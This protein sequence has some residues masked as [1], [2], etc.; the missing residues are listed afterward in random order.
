MGT[1]IFGC[2]AAES[3]DSSGEILKMDGLDISTLTHDGIFNYEH[4]NDQPNQVVG[5]ILFAKKLMSEED[6]TRPQEKY[7]WD[8]VKIPMLYV[9]GELFDDVGHSSAQ[10]IAAMLKYDD[11]MRKAGLLKDGKIK[12]MINFSIEGAKLENEGNIIKKSIA[13]KVTITIL[14]CNKVCEAEIY[15]PEDWGSEDKEQTS[16]KTKE[17]KK[18]S[19]FQQHIMSKSESTGQDL[20]KNESMTKA[21]KKPVVPT[22][23]GTTASG[24]EISSHHAGGYSGWG[25]QDHKE[26]A[27]M[28]YQAF[29]NASTPSIKNHHL[30]QSQFHVS[31][32]NRMESAAPKTTT[33]PNTASVKPIVGITRQYSQIP[34]KDR[35]V[36]KNQEGVH[37]PSSKKGVSV[38]GY[39]QRHAQ[40]IK[41]AGNK[42]ILGF[43]HAV[44]DEHKAV[45]NEMKNQPK[46][47][48]PKSELN[49][50]SSSKFN[51]RQ[52][53][54]KHKLSISELSQATRIEAQDLRNYEMGNKMH[55]DHE[56][57]IKDH[58]NSRSSSSLPKSESAPSSMTG[59]QAL[60]KETLVKLMYKHEKDLDVAWSTWNKAEKFRDFLQDRMPSMSKEE[61]TAL[62][63]LLRLA[64]WKKAES[65]AEKL[66]G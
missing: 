49:K 3:L 53:R 7:V 40:G 43:E 48:L 46:P 41:R 45:L 16:T 31:M 20:S 35:G 66:L 58:F 36:A 59:N 1:R 38:A 21:I 61:V 44:K 47:S 23:L 19:A 17:G 57:K 51:L 52:E 10:D 42:D 56:K 28:H 64:E 6:C 30:R 32:A 11:K 9:E 63:K 37:R 5:K 39:N 22:V 25:H 54:M 55:P 12:P 26:A 29:E 62:A 24:K 60:Q 8:K 2:G 33:P 27:N 14:A 13:R 4:K 65:S 34:G 15:R 18:L 50:S